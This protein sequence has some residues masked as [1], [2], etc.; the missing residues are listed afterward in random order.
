LVQFL[1]GFEE[2]IFLIKPYFLTYFQ[3]QRIMLFESLIIATALF[4]S[5]PENTTPTT[6]TTDVPTTHFFAPED[7]AE[8]TANFPYDMTY[9]YAYFELDDLLKNISGL[10]PTGMSAKS[11]VCVQKEDG[12]AYL[13][14]KKTGKINSS[15]F[16]TTEGQFEGVEMVGDTMFAIKDNGQ[17]YKIWNLNSTSKM[18]RQVKLNLPRTEMMEGLGYDLQNNRLLMTAKGQKE[19]DFSKKIYSLDVK[20]NQSNPIPAYEITLAQFKEFL[21]DKK[22]DRAY[23]KLH[24]DYVA[25]ANPKNFD[26]IPASIAINPIDNNIYVL[27]SFN[28]VVMVMNPQG[29]I[30]DIQKLKK[31]MNNAPNGLCFDEEG[32]MYISNEAKDGKP[33]KLVEYKASKAAVTAARLNSNRK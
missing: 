12:K 15:V 5:T 25:K 22:A 1:K 6:P 18:V 7:V 11:I 10:S 30:V 33:A 26:F 20:T 27:S 8:A 13:V 19:G 28:S 32:T 9:P 31:D 4:A 23:M 17:L 16:F 29:K 14:D 2:R 21:A 3:T 24:E